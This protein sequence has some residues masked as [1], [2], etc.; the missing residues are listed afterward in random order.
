MKLK[1]KVKPNSGR[2]EIIKDKEHYIVYLKS[3]PEKNKA[4]M[5]LIKLLKEYFDKEV[6]IS[7][8]FISRNKVVE[9]FE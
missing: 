5:E 6:K 9:I 2:Q 3:V 4:N 1:I 8:G 7:S